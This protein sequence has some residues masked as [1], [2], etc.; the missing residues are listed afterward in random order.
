MTI[1]FFAFLI[2]LIISALICQ[3]NIKKEMAK[4]K[5][6]VEK[7]NEKIEVLLSK[8]TN[9]KEHCGYVSADLP[10]Q[11]VNLQNKLS[12]FTELLFK[13]IDENTKNNSDFINKSLNDIKK[14]LSDS[15]EMIGDLYNFQPKMLNEINDGYSDFVEK[16]TKI[17]LELKEHILSKQEISKGEYLIFIKLIFDIF[18]LKSTKTIFECID[19]EV[20]LH[21]S[22][23]N[24]QY[25][26][27]INDICNDV[28]SSLENIKYIFEHQV[29]TKTQILALREQIVDEV[30]EK[31]N[32]FMISKSIKTIN[33]FNKNEIKTHLS[34]IIIDICEQK[35][36]EVVDVIRG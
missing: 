31:M 27:K 34:N 23:K 20:I 19:D 18:I 28:L 33:E 4:T 35:K 26:S 10:K 30:F 14:Q 5:E 1:Y 25:K 13:I 3:N 6:K 7:T 15:L 11:I 36:I 24:T 8:L 12:E 16:T 21:F 9:N 32:Q 22:T 29:Y 17:F 2:L